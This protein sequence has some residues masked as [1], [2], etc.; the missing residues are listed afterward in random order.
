MLKHGYR[1]QRA[2]PVLFCFYFY[3]SFKGEINK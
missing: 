3:F 2:L 1:F